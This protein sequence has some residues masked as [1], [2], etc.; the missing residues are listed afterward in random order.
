[1]VSF[2]FSNF[3]VHS[4]ASTPHGFILPLK[5][6]LGKFA[7][8]FPE[9]NQF[10]AGLVPSTSLRTVRIEQIASAATT[11]QIDTTLATWNIT[12]L[13]VDFIISKRRSF[14]TPCSDQQRMI[15]DS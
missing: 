5:R 6:I 3:A 2:I 7:H 12:T 15:V 8:I 13:V 9:L 4:S 11:R 1:L 10:F 14:Y